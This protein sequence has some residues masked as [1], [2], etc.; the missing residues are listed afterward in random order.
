M[1]YRKLKNY[2]AFETLNLM[3][4]K[5]SMIQALLEATTQIFEQIHPTQ[6]VLSSTIKTPNQ[7]NGNY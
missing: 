4:K 2:V 7:S 6:V 3:I 1:L 5:L